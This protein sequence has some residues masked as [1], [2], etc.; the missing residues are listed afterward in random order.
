M[1]DQPSIYGT[2]PT[3]R[4]QG[5]HSPTDFD[6]EFI[7]AWINDHGKSKFDTRWI[8]EKYNTYASKVGHTI[9]EK[10]MICLSKRLCSIDGI[11]KSRTTNWRFIELVD[12][13]KILHYMNQRR[14]YI[15]H[16]TLKEPTVL[17]ETL[18]IEWVNENNTNSTPPRENSPEENE[19]DHGQELFGE[20]GYG[21]WKA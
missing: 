8:L 19:E 12:L 5:R 4:S 10:S 15:T 7:G 18:F 6:L 16:G 14:V 1:L 13:D 11:E 20:F 9:P 2:K 17:N 21:P 3:P